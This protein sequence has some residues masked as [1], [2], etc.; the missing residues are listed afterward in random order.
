MYLPILHLPRVELHWKLHRVPGPSL[1]TVRSQASQRTLRHCIHYYINI[2]YLY[3]NV[4]N[5]VTCAGMPVV[6]LFEA[7]KFI[8]AFTSGTVNDP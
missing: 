6:R 5:D 4:C 3:N 8:T 2:L 7:Q 1:F